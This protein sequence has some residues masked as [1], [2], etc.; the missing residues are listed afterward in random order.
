MKCCKSE[1]RRIALL[2]VTAMIFVFVFLELRPYEIHHSSIFTSADSTEIQLYIIANTFLP[3][4]EEALVGRVLEDHNRL[5]GEREKT[6]Y[7]LEIYRTIIH[8][9]QNWKYDT[10]FCDEKR[11]IVLKCE[12]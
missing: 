9:K 7:R 12:Q 4:N 2:I 10:V 11:N 5:N 8:Y 1:V 3:I 6:V